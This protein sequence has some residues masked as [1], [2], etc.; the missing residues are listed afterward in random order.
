LKLSFEKLS[1]D[2]FF[3]NEEILVKKKVCIYI[4]YLS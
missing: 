4:E 2:I 1:Y 3:S